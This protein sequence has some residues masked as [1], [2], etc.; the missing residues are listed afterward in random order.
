MDKDNQLSIGQ[1]SKLLNI[2]GNTLRFFDKE[3]IVRA[4]RADNG[5]RYYDDWDI[6]FLIEYK[7]YRSFGLSVEDAKDVLYRDSLESLTDR[8]AENEKAIEEKIRRLK[9]LLGYNKNYCA[10]LKTIKDKIGARIVTDMP[11]AEYFPMRYNKVYVCRPD[12][13]ELFGAWSDEFPFVE[14]IL[15]VNKPFDKDYQCALSVRDEYQKEICLPKNLLVKQTLKGRALNTVI[16]GGEKDTFST[17]LLNETY[18]Y[19]EDNGMYRQ[20]AAIGYYL[21][22]VHEDGIY[23][24]YI[25]MYIPI[26]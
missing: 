5:Y 8:L 24:R 20:G 7:K 13:S 11:D 6:N 16:V 3:G 1:V 2:P 18:K 25:D 12:V 21:A 22:R 10:R 4:K 23:R 9:M 15:I 17:E 26:K 19:I 14:P